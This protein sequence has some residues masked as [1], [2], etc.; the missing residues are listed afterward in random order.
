MIILNG[1][2]CYLNFITYPQLFMLMILGKM[3]CISLASHFWKMKYQGKKAIVD[4]HN[5]ACETVFQWL[6]KF[7][8]IDW[9]ATY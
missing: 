4:I 1:F 6:R 5:V 3:K 7:K 8:S 9:G 2:S